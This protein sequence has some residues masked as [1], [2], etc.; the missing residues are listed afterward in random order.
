MHRE[1][2]QKMK[3][4][5]VLLLVTLLLA[6]Y[7]Y[8]FEVRKESKTLST[9]ESQ[10][11][12]KTLVGAQ[13]DDIRGFTLAKVGG[14]PITVELV[15]KEWVMT[16]PVNASAEEATVNGVLW[17]LEWAEKELTVPASDVTPD[18]LVSYGLDKPV[19][20]VDVVL[21]GKGEIRTVH[22]LVGGPSLDA[23]SVY[24]RAESTGPVYLVKKDFADEL[25]TTVHKMRNKTVIPLVA[26][27]VGFLKIGGVNKATLEKKESRWNLIEPFADYADVEKVT[28]VLKDASSLQVISF[29]SDDPA[30]LAD[31]GLDKPTAFVTVAE[32][33]AGGKSV[34]VNIGSAAPDA[35]SGD[36]LVYAALGAGSSVFTLKSATVDKL[37]PAVSDL[38]SKSLARFDPYQLKKLT[39]TLGLGE[40]ELSKPDFNWK[41]TRPYESD[42]DSSA[43]SRVITAFQ[44]AE[45]SQFVTAEPERDKYGFETARGSF[46]STEAGK[47]PL[48]IVFGS[49][50]G[51]DTV[52]ARR[53]DTPGVYR[54]SK[55]ILKTLEIPALAYHTLEMQKVDVTQ[56]D[57]LDIIRGE[58]SYS[59]KQQPGKFGADQ[60]RMTAP[61]D[62]PANSMMMVTLSTALAAT[63]AVELLESTASGLTTYGLDKP[64][65]RIDFHMLD[66]AEAPKSLL[67]GKPAGQ[68]RRYA[69]L[70]G[71]PFVFTIASSVARTVFDEVRDTAAFSFRP[72]DVSRV[73]FTVGEKK[74][75][76]AKSDNTWAVEE[77]EDM[78]VP[79][80]AID[81]ELAELAGLATDK[82]VTYK[83]ADLAQYGLEKPQAVV[84]VTLASGAAALSVGTL[85]PT[86]H[87]YATS[88]TVD[89]VFLLTPGDAAMLLA[90]DRLLETPV[91]APGAAEEPPQ[92]EAPEGEGS[93]SPS[94]DSSVPAPE[95]PAVG[96]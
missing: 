49:D 41:V 80:S 77:P 52:Y 66:G 76:L 31:Y 21:S 73:E 93:P 1:V 25:N 51:D 15:N 59:L 8:Y 87:Y 29:T 36:K 86:G 14:Q 58:E 3:K 37:F 34:T 10:T 84:R 4:S 20:S 64:A 57:S 62:A 48:S 33:A 28:G 45:T 12:A 42:A 53:S 70:D 11:L 65:A 24:V 9:D 68:G 19:G 26:S 95:T 61:A 43:V 81:A 22:F 83:S 44:N 71:S 13:K 16:A 54:V 67:I 23:K 92:R 79:K 60:W 78:T 47:A 27:Q 82:F 69:M 2:S 94:S 89:G 5:L 50:A 75:T 18:R 96:D 63:S 56:V 74:V 55:D 46:T 72:S 90:P 40:I 85:A 88:T 39:L 17:Q 30:K 35:E 91:L 32:S 7:V 38:Q 6:A